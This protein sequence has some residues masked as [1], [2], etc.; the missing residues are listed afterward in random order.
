VL[1]GMTDRIIEQAKEDVAAALQANM[2]VM[3]TTVKDNL[4]LLDKAVK[5]HIQSINTAHTQMDTA[6][7]KVIKYDEKLRTLLNDRLKSNKASIARLFEV[8]GFKR[9]LFWVGL[10]CSILTP[11]V[12]IAIFLI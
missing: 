3:N 1:K 2:E 12:L 6:N 10:A 9:F 5:G 7:T 11:I 8:D 4:S